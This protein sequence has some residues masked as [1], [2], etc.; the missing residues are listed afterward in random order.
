MRAV[1]P[2]VVLGCALLPFAIGLGTWA[3]FEPDEGRNAEIAREMLA[4]GDW[5]VPHL[6]GLPFLDKPPLLFWALAAAFRFLGQSESIAR[7]PSMLAAFA[8]IA[9][10]Y[11]L[12]RALL[13]GRRAATGAIVL[14]TCPM[15]LVFGRLVIF[16][17]PLT[18]FVTGAVYAMVRAR[19]DDD[20]WRWLPLAGV[21][22]GLALLTKGPVGLAL[23]LVVWVAV[24]GV[25]PGGHARQARPAFA[26]AL[27]VAIVMIGSWVA[28]VMP[29]EP[30]FLRYA[31]VDET[32][33]RVGSA[34]H[35]HR[36]GPP[37][38]YLVTVPW[39]LG[40]WVFP[41]VLLGPTLVRRLRA[42]GPDAMAIRFAAR[43]AGT[44]IVFF[45]LSAS[46]RPQ[47][48][49]PALV[50]LSLLVA[51][52]MT[53]HPRLTGAILRAGGWI[54]A[55]VGSG[56]LMLAGMG[57]APTGLPSNIPIAE[58][59]PPIGI[60]LLTWGLV[61]ARAARRPSRAVVCAAAFAPLVMLATLQPLAI[62]AERRSARRVAAN[63]PADAPVVCFDTFRTSLPFYLKRSVTV[64]SDLGDALTSN[65]VVSQ[66]ARLREPTL[67]F[68][69]S[70]ADVLAGNPISYVLIARGEV[71]RLRSFAPRHR[72]VVVARDERSALL[73]A[74]SLADVDLPLACRDTTIGCAQADGP[75]DRDRAALARRT[76]DESPSP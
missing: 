4:S 37:Y 19:L 43:A 30:D 13:D 61:T 26:L 35:F 2:L 25:L 24:R 58:M 10:T 75:F 69:G 45:T 18:A 46:K 39:A 76:G 56:A 21:L 50:P 60:V 42:G 47:Y 52:G 28:A 22:M 6:N 62:Y 41:L 65:Y 59:L 44:I 38:Y 9:C 55:I 12:G 66:R 74:S 16:D 34:A 33:L 14:A 63:I 11:A 51:I 49:L 32:L 1:A 57:I 73:R 5:V 29:R 54:A 40:I 8:T 64:L 68:E 31:F 36:G 27:V 7:L 70:L 71:T 15:I 67:G 48:I 3:L 20:A 72:L 53:A 23:P 17:M